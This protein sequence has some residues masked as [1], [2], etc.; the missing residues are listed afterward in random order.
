MKEDIFLVRWLRVND[1]NIPAAE[2]M[3]ME[4]LIFIFKI[5]AYISTLYCYIDIKLLYAECKMERRK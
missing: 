2:K 1:F 4:V 3:I 5:V